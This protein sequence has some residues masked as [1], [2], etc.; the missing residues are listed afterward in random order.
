VTLDLEREPI[1]KDAQGR[2]VYLRDLW[3]S[4]EEVAALLGAARRADSYRENYADVSMQNEGWNAIPASGGAL[5][6]WDASSTYIQEPPYFE[7]VGSRPPAI[8]DVSG[9]RILAI[10]GDGISTDHISPAGAI[11][12]TSPAGRYLEEK[13][14]APAR[15][16][17]YGARRG[18]HH[19]MIRG[20]FANPR[21]RN[22]LVPGVE[23]GWTVLQ[24]GGRRA[25]IDEAARAY[26]ASRT[27]L[28]VFAGA[29]YGSGSSRDWAAK[30]TALLGVRVV[31]ARS[32][33]RIH[34][35]NLVMM[36]VLPCELPEGIDA[37]SLGLTG[38]EI[39]DVVGLDA[40]APRG[41]ATLRLHQ[42]DG[43]VAEIR[44]RVRIDTP[45]E[46]EIYENGGILPRVFRKFLEGS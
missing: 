8:E 41:E 6:E 2:D 19:V 38:D 45:A 29:E 21:I 37:G 24:P 30:G 5:Y 33:E 12:A 20:T 36:G 34:R 18:N 26:A 10:F 16:N 15:F 40:L 4:S 42:R 7:G 44:L 27:P 1:A 23:G 31:V 25:T 32:F 35:S 3:P 22:L 39:V 17:S 46:L 13:G 28:V 11:A 14:V 9:A 43:T